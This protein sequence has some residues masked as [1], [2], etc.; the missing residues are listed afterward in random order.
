MMRVQIPLKSIFFE[1]T[2]HKLINSVWNVKSFVFRRKIMTM[3]SCG[4]KRYIFCSCTTLPMT[5]FHELL[6][7]SQLSNLTTTTTICNTVRPQLYSDRFNPPHDVTLSNYYSKWRLKR[8]FF[9]VTRTV[10]SLFIFCC[11]CPLNRSLF[12]FCQI[13]FLFFIKK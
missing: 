10:T 13:L 11:Q 5:D 4:G 1:L 2:L 8:L 7:F 6:P 12:L 3:T 9:R